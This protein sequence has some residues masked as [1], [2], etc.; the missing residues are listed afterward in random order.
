MCQSRNRKEAK[1]Y[2]KPQY[3]LHFLQLSMKQSNNWCYFYY[4][5]VNNPGHWICQR[6]ISQVLSTHSPQQSLHAV[7][8]RN[9]QP[10]NLLPCY[11]QIALPYKI[12]EPPLPLIFI[13]ALA[14][15][16]YYNILRIL[17]KEF[18]RLLLFRGTHTAFQ[19]RKQWIYP[20]L[21]TR[22]F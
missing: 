2:V 15:S 17:L 12:C 21:F 16:F 22:Y 9:T 3:H 18:S 5:N 19:E 7:N 13:Y 4:F 10:C 1:S 8:D 11:L 20:K 6:Q 14:F